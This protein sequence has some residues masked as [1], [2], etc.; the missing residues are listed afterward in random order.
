MIN[1]ENLKLENSYKKRIIQFDITRT[2]AIFCVVLCHCV[3]TIYAMSSKNISFKSKIVMGVSFTI[4]RIGVPLFFFLTGALILRKTI[5]KDEDVLTFYKKNLIP[6]IVTNEI[7]V[8]IY[9]LFFYLAKQT[10]KLTLTNIIKELLFLKQVP[11]PQFW[12]MPVIVGIYIAIPFV[13]KIVKTFSIKSLIVPLIFLIVSN[14][15]LSTINNFFMIFGSNERWN[16]LMD[17]TFLGGGYGTYILIGYY[18]NNSKIK[19]NKIFTWI[20]VIITF[21]LAVA[22]QFISHCNFTVEVYNIWYNNIFLLCCTSGIFILLKDMDE[23]KINAKLSKIFI[24]ISKISFG[25]YLIHYIVMYLIKP[26]IVKVGL[27]NKPIKIILLFVLTSLASIFSIYILSKV[28]CIK[29]YVFRI[30]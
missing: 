12:Y 30:K 23:K 4:G 8:I 17:L 1:E 19:I 7:W 2:L 15:L 16:L 18:I 13:A 14:F 26:Y 3:E 9:N 21:L 22:M 11:A 25:I 29:K 28:K 24:Y 6:L 27:L 20:F 5:E 10:D